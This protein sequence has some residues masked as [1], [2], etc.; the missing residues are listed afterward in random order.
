MLGLPLCL[1]GLG[2]GAGG[3]GVSTWKAKSQQRNW[4][5]NNYFRRIMRAQGT[6]AKNFP[7]MYFC[8]F[9]GMQLALINGE[10]SEDFGKRT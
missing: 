4:D 2:E 9:F 7:A 8:V 10:H 5:S 3:E 6:A 1:M